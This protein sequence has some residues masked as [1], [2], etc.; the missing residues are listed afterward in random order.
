MGYSLNIPSIEFGIPL[1]K[2]FND[3]GK[4]KTNNATNQ[5]N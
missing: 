5:G 4:D 1:K 3:Y 2:I